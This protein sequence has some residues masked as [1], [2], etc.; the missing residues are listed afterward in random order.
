[1]VPRNIA[2]LK[3]YLQSKEKLIINLDKTYDFTA[4]EG[5]GTE[6]GCVYHKCSKTTISE[7][8]LAH[9]GTCNGRPQTTVRGG[10]SLVRMYIRHLGQH[11]ASTYL[12]KRSATLYQEQN[13]VL[14]GFL[15][16]ILAPSCRSKNVGPECLF[17]EKHF[18]ISSLKHN[19][20]TL[21][22]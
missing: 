22:I 10:P 15:H 5:F 18:G 9:S 16:F 4:S 2:E 8:S 19:I 17:R 13:Y 1:M 11:V 3:N 7:L 14:V 12:A 6:K 20:T 21:C